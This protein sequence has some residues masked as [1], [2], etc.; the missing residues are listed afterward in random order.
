MISHRIRVKIIDAFF[1]LVE[2]RGWEQITLPAIAERARIKPAKL[3]QIYRNKFEILADYA[4]QMDF[5]VLERANADTAGLG[6]RQRLT[7]MLMV[8]FE[9]MGDRRSALK[10]LH[11][12]AIADRRLA[13]GFAGVVMLSNSWMQ[14]AAGISASGL[15]GMVKMQGLTVA[16]ARAFHAWLDDEEPELPNTLD[17]LDKTLAHGEK[18]L[19]VRERLGGLVKPFLP[20]GG[21]VLDLEANTGTAAA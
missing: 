11:H 7:R 16:F 20:N 14:T 8:R 4:E 18:A 21:G 13:A 10:R 3:K 5:A 6:P 2:E 9:L 12:A 15:D 17:V 1:A 19:Y